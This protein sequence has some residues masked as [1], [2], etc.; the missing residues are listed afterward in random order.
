MAINKMLIQR[1]NE[2]CQETIDLLNK[3][4]KCAILRPTGFGKT[5]IMCKISRRYKNVLY[6]YPTEIIKK[7][8]ISTVSRMKAKDN[9]PDN[10]TF[11]T[12]SYF[13]KMHNNLD[14]V[15]EFINEKHFDLIIFDEIHHMGAK[16]VKETLKVLESID[17]SHT[18]IL[19]GTATPDRMDGYDVIGEY[20]NNSIVS[21]YG[22]DNMIEDGIMPK[23]YYVYATQGIKWALDRIVETKENRLEE[24]SKRF[25]PT[26]EEVDLR[27]KKTQIA[28]LL[29]AHLIIRDAVDKVY[30]DNKPEYMR[31]MVF[32]STKDILDKKK[33]EVYNW[34][35]TAFPSYKVNNPL[36]IHSGYAERE[37]LEQLPK[38]NETSNTI[39]LV[40]S[41]NMLNEGYHTGT[42][43]GCILL[44]P[45]QSQI[46][47]TQQVGR[48]LQ[49]GLKNSPIIIDLV[50][51]LSTNALFGINTASINISKNNNELM[52]DIQKFNTI[53]A[54][55]IKV[56]NRVA[57]VE[58]LIER[59]NNMTNNKATEEKIIS[60][61]IKYTESVSDLALQYK[62]PVFKIMQILSKHEDELKPLGLQLQDLDR[63]TDMK[64]YII[65]ENKSEIDDFDEMVNS[66]VNK[67]IQLSE[68]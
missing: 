33:T 2:T 8:V 55:N 15:I 25:K 51:N 63:Y 10:I 45:T 43:T 61:R 53:K 12:Y 19:G 60:D 21:F 57:K 3:T 62:L 40:L 36:I 46:V 49:V 22:F 31:F 14:K 9:L 42:I 35:K 28:N 16:L 1:A 6:I 11:C 5:V 20:F 44:R 38:L 17:T 39:D 67:V 59:I 24:E 37:N 64:G 54:D 65:G 4:G 47:Y 48:C 27:S 58:A 52:K 56:D 68:E 29:D 34:F 26:N 50:E 7:H 13:G 32:F 23:P 41:I 18:H 66:L 30:G